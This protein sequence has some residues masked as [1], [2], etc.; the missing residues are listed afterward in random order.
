MLNLQESLN[1]LRRWRA[2][3]LANT[4]ALQ[5]AFIAIASIALV[6][7][8]SLAVIYWVEASTQHERLQEKS[9]RVVERLEASIKVVESSVTALANNPMFMTALLDSKGRDSYV[10]PFL[11]NYNFPIA[12]SSGLALCDINGTRLAG[13]RS[14]LSN[15]HPD[16]ALFKQVMVDG[17]TL[18]ELA[19]LPNGHLGWTVYHGVVFG[20]TGTVEGVVVTQLD[21]ND[22][23]QSV[24]KDLDLSDVALQRTGSTEVLVGVQAAQDA[25]A[26]LQQASAALFKDQPEALPYPLEVVV[27][28]RFQPFD[29]KLLPLGLGYGLAGLLMVL[30]VIVWARRVSR[31]LI[32][33]L[34]ELTN[35]AHQ[36]AETGD[37]GI[38]VPKTSAGEVA[39]LAMAFEVMVNAVRISESSLEEKVALRTAQLEQSQAT[40]R[41][42]TEQLNAIFDLSP[43][44][45]VSFDA[46]RKVTFANLAFLRMTGTEA[47]DIIGQDEAQFS[48]LLASKCLP[49][50]VFPGVDALRL[51]RKNMRD[52]G[53]PA[54][55]VRIRHCLIELAG[56]G[57]RVLEVGIRLSQAENV[58]QILYLR[59]VTHETEVD[60]MKSEFLTT[61]AHELRTPMA[62]IYGYCELLLMRDFDADERKD[63]LSTI[64]RQS[65]LMA[66]IINEL[67]DLARIEA[68]RGKDFVLERLSLDELVN[69]AVAGYK[70]PAGREA[71]HIRASNETLLVRVDRKKIQQALLNVLANAYKY[72]P[73]G[74][75]ICLSFLQEVH[76]SVGRFGIEVRD[77]GIGMR[78]EEVARVFERFYRADSTGKIPGTGLGMS[79]VRE[80]VEIHGGEVTVESQLGEG[81]TVTLWL[82]AA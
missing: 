21:L 67:L 30:L 79:I 65:E 26:N 71:P 32:A 49:E 52:D 69:E 19:L 1:R 55:Q 18:R 14:P 39:Q 31:V 12:A 23:L 61:A 73:R 72:S 35:T 11:G 27:R 40:N 28:D 58:S 54:Q 5:A 42:R 3:S 60:R 62:S 16:S 70:L 78:P 20:Y 44:G 8:M 56:P 59:D 64:F 51:E 77:H 36:V 82:P 24:P 9:G 63:M 46:E 17:K 68:R 41:D 47:S 34:T 57:Q 81:T 74:G 7:L 76:H 13:T 45:F 6:A 2:S 22:I 75:S 10:V 25:P 37:L 4:F 80:I 53:T 48:G 66:S 50:S 29:N 43:D 15:C 33:P 38:A